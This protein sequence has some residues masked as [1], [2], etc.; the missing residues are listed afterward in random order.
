MS[1]FN[2]SAIMSLKEHASKFKTLMGHYNVILAQSAQIKRVSVAVKNGVY[3]SSKY[4]ERYMTC[5]DSNTNT[6]IIY[7]MKTL[8]ETC[9]RLFYDANKMRAD[10]KWRHREISTIINELDIDGDASLL[11]IT[12]FPTVQETVDDYKV[13]IVWY[14]T[15]ASQYVDKSHIMYQDIM[16]ETTTAVNWYKYANNEV[17]YANYTP[18]PDILERIYLE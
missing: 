14:A 13:A 5:N 10:I 17:K 18:E 11:F 6:R 4:S 3:M 2:S 1:N 15:Y 12:P 16:L 8:M 7:E 9:H